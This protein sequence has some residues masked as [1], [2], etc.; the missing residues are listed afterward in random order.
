M[1]AES[2]TPRNNASIVLASIAAIVG[3]LVF[4]GNIK[5]TPEVQAVSLESAIE[6]QAPLPPITLQQL[7]EKL[8]TLRGE[9]QESIEQARRDDAGQT[10]AAIA[11]AVADRQTA[12]QTALQTKLDEQSKELE[13]IQGAIAAL[14]KQQATT[15]AVAAAASKTATTKQATTT[16]DTDVPTRYYYTETPGDYAVY[17]S[18]QSQPTVVTYRYYSNQP[19]STI[20]YQTTTECENGACSVQYSSRRSSPSRASTVRYSVP[21]QFRL[22]SDCS[23]G[24][25]AP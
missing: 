3:F 18:V 9:L 19:T 2:T 1:T 6:S 14:S 22:T 17:R 24:M 15:A 23:N 4:N 8:D 16:S 12:L 5:L 11:T 10:N 7:E 13:K 20:Q 21:M 25:C